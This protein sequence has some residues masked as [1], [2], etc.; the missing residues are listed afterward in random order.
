ME[1]YSA[2]HPSRP[3]ALGVVKPH[4]QFLWLMEVS[5]RDLKLALGKTIFI[6]QSHFCNG[7]FSRTL[8]GI[9]KRGWL[10][11]ICSVRIVTAVEG[12]AA[13]G[14]GGLGWYGSTCSPTGGLQF[15]SSPV[16]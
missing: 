5:F 2:R 1:F 13:F 8:C 6:S 4:G 7:L 9:T 14:N 12:A 3:A 16:G 10:A 11:A 15:F